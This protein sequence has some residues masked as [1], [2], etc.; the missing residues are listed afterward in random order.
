MR[1]NVKSPPPTTHEGATAKRISPKQELRRTLM[2][3]L[4]WESEF[5]ESGVSIA[6]RI[7]DLVQRN[8][9]GDVAAMAIE[10]R[11]RM[12]LRHV[13]L[14]LCRELARS[15]KMLAETLTEVIQRPDEI[16]EFLAL[17]W[18]DNKNEPLSHQVKKGLREAFRKFN[19]YSLAKYNGGNSAV[20]LRDAIRIVRPKP[21][22]ENQANLWGRLVKGTMETPDTW[23]VE[24]SKGGD[25]KESWTRLLNEN[26]LGPMAL[27]RNLRN[28]S[29]VGVDNKLVRK[30]LSECKPEKVLPFRFI[31][32][33]RAVPSMEDAIEP[34]MLCCLESA[35]KLSGKTALVIDNSGSMHGPKISTKSDID[36]S[37][38]ACALSILIRE[39]CEQCMVISFSDQPYIVPNRRGFALADAVKRACFPGGTNTRHALELAQVWGYDR[40]IVVTDEQ[41]HQTIGGPIPGSKGYFVNVASCQ[42]GIGYGAWCH[43]DGWSE[44]IVEYIRMA[45]SV[46]QE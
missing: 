5:Y 16:T 32:A 6:D 45:E 15:H 36:R 7:A 33:A 18:K 19:E 8:K 4:L 35:E 43:L 3:C 22:T 26:R 10:A 14:K 9:P 34:T 23:E 28:M 41:S 13:P 25:K 1:T 12:H 30:A 40:I 38:A 11:S 27:L 44:A 29:Q 31:A 2:S 37:D 46:E 21:K 20:K 42:Q 39:V 17:Y 24:L